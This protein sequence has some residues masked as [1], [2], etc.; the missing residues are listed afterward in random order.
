VLPL[1]HE[2]RLHEAA[3]AIRK[4]HYRDLMERWRSLETKAQGTIA[5]TGILIAGILAFIRELEVNA[6]DLERG[7]LATMLTASIVALVLGV[8]ALWIRNVSEAP[9]GVSVDRLIPNHI[10]DFSHSDEAWRNVVREQV[11]AWG[12][13]ITSLHRANQAKA[14]LVMFGQAAL[15]LAA[16][17]AVVFCVMRIIDPSS[18]PVTS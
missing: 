5:T 11:T 12:V 13:T 10:D 16:L 8:L 4:E 3:L 6:S 2:V 1:N 18:P 15:A 14:W 17:L 9:F 7:L